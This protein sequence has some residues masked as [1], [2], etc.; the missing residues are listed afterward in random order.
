MFVRPERS[1]RALHRRPC[2]VPFDCGPAGLRSGRTGKLL[3]LLS[4]DHRLGVGEAVEHVPLVGL[5]A[6]SDPAEAQE[7]LEGAMT[8]LGLSA[9]A[10]DRIIKVSRTIADLAGEP[11]I[12]FDHISEA[13]SYRTLDRS[14]SI[15]GPVG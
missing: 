10:F 2:N 5:G 1:R 4:P 3:R 7:A 9:R 8:T 15:A 13:I 6:G 12:T 11:D 14:E